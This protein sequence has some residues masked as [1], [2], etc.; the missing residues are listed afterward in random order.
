MLDNLEF[1]LIQKKMH[2][3]LILSLG[4]I[5]EPKLIYHHPPK[6]STKVANQIQSVSVTLSQQKNSNRLDCFGHGLYFMW[7]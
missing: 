7:F 2:V 6:T 5:F 3:T 4:M 1:N